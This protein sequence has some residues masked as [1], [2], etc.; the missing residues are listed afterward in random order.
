MQA[1]MQLTLAAHGILF[2]KSKCVLSWFDQ[3]LA[4]PT[5]APT[6]RG[7]PAHPLAPDCEH[8]LVG[9]LADC[10]P[11]TNRIESTTINLAPFFN[12]R[13]WHHARVIHRMFAADVTGKHPKV[14]QYF[15]HVCQ[16][17][18]NFVTAPRDNPVAIRPAY[19][20]ALGSLCAPR[21]VEMD[22]FKG[23]KL[24]FR[25]ALVLDGRAA[26][27]FFLVVATIPNIQ[28]NCF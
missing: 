8:V 1:E 26:H 14:Q 23:K 3:A 17:F 6:V 22:E 19:K 9:I 11:R 16:E 20:A 27:T 4:N 21:I 13:Y 15:Q 7:L 25:L 5:M 2:M 18:H 28:F 24:V 10:F 12:P